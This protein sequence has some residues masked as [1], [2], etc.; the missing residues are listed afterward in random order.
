MRNQTSF[1]RPSKI[2]EGSEEAD[3]SPGSS[4]CDT[5]PLSSPSPPWLSAFVMFL[6]TLPEG[7][8]VWGVY[9][10]LLIYMKSRVTWKPLKDPIDVSAKPDLPHPA[11]EALPLH[12][13]AGGSITPLRTHTGGQDLFT[14]C[15]FD[16]DSSSFFS[17]P[18]ISSWITS[19]DFLS[20]HPDHT[21]KLVNRIKAKTE[22]L[23]TP[24]KTSLQNVINSSIC[25]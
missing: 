24:I 22:P 25:S 9:I 15:F 6:L 14:S 16:P 2:L 5:V 10:T 18:F 17:S 1:P 7:E 12:P 19:V 20:L 11:L 21:L 8:L 3:V 4:R 23:G 13:G